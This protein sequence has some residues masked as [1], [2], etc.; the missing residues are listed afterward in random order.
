MW[1]L[2][3]LMIQIA[4]A[5]WDAWLKNGYPLYLF[6]KYWVLWVLLNFEQLKVPEGLCK[7][8]KTLSRNFCYF[9]NFFTHFWHLDSTTSKTEEESWLNHHF[10]KW[11]LR[12]NY[13]PKHSCLQPWQCTMNFFLAE[14]RQKCCSL[15]C[16]Q[17][18]FGGFPYE[19]VNAAKTLILYQK[20][21]ICMTI[22][23]CSGEKVQ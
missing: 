10:I 4:V 9:T 19:H 11:K 5:H 2:C 3:L 16:C 15:C 14:V 1:I 6:A 8:N 20:Y 23:D 18:I 21:I 17:A 12:E 22:I 7:L 13:N